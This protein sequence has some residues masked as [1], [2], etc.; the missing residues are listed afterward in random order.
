M[1]TFANWP[2]AAIAAGVAVPALLLL[3]F[4][5]L[6][7][8]ELDVPSTL[9]WRKAIKDLQVNAP[10]QRLRRNLLL[11][12]QLLVLLLLA[13]ALARP[14]LNYT[15]GAAPISVILID[16]S[17]SMTAPD[18][19]EGGRTRLDEAKRLARDLVDSMDKDAQAMV[20]AFDDS[21]EIVRAFTRDRA[22]LKAAIDGIR[23]T[24]RRSALK[25]AF[26]LAEA[27]T[28]AFRTDNAAAAGPRPKVYVYSDGRVRDARELSLRY[29]ELEY[30]KIGSDSAKNVAIVAMSARRNFERPTEVQVFARLANHGPEPTTCVV[31]L[32]VENVPAARGLR[33]LTLVPERWTPEQRQRAAEA[34]TVGQE[35]VEFKVELTTSAVVRVEVKENAED[36]IRADDVAQVVVP[37]PRSLSV[38]LVT[39]KGNLWLERFLETAQVRKPA[40]LTPAAYRQRVADPQKLAADFDVIVFD[41]YS[42]EAL[43]PAGNFLFNQAVPPNSRVRQA[44]DVTGV[45]LTMRRQVVLDWDR[46]HP[47]L[48]GLNVRFL[49]NEALRLSLPPEARTLV[50]GRDG[51]L[52]VLHREARSTH[53]IFA[54]DV[55]DSS[56]PTSASYPAFMTATLQ[57]LAL[58]TDMDVRESFQPG[59]TPRLPRYNLLQ[60]G[61]TKELTLTDPTGARHKLEVPEVGDFALPALEHVGIYQ[62]DP[63][64]PQFERLA[65]NLLDPVESNVQPSDTPPG[66]SGTAQL[67]ASAKGRLDL[68]WWIVACAAVPLLLVEWYVYTR[69]V[70]L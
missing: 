36:A 32:S 34:G 8:K 2:A 4:L 62:T 23:P 18:G 22:V 51:P 63:A 17:A 21:A 37:P 33:R 9:L 66:G 44:K 7:R 46:E 57:F 11:F 10:F 70:H 49:A 1:P 43:P 26:Q 52:I 60:A 28:Q 38:A 16:R 30:W 47:L 6:R 15:P 40:I 29:A 54:F 58:G 42:P 31:Q 14:I 13:L 27:Q 19:G 41:R 59:D 48:R 3:Y 25:T 45:N 35:A 39:D 61:V 5:K 56:W 20:M 68:W 12:L 65:V 64:V 24:D 69:R 50:E 53:L 55:G 67:A